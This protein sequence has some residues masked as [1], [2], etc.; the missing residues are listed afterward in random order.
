MTAEIRSLREEDLD[1][2]LRLSQFAFQYE[3]APEEV[4]QRKKRMNPSLTL[5][6][7]EDG[8]M[9]AKA[10]FLPLRAFIAGKPFAMGGVAGV[11]TWP[12]HRR[13]GKVEALLRRGLTFMRERGETV[14][15]LAPF[16]F[17][18][19]ARYG[20]TMLTERKQYTF[21]SGRV[22]QLHAFEIPEGG[23]IRRVD[24]KSEWQ[25]LN[26]VYRQHAARFNGMLDRD[27]DWWQHSVLG[28]RKGQAAVYF[29][30]D[31]TAQGYLLY[32]VAESEVKVQEAVWLDADAQGALLKFLANHDSMAKS[33]EM[34]V[35]ASDRLPYLLRNPNLKQELKPYFMFRVVDVEAFVPAYP[36]KAVAGDLSV[37]LTDEHAP[38]NA[39]AYTWQLDSSGRAALTRR[40]LGDGDESIR[41]D[42]AAFSAMMIGAARPVFLRETGRLSGSDEAVR[43][44]ESALPKCETY[45]QDFF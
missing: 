23:G 20:W 44:W 8:A 27:E 7:F 41:C 39:G 4:E 31:G 28:Q 10:S 30:P 15:M 25:L 26:E 22:A 21:E 38:W 42:I 16:S 40:Q 3:L 34:T 13:T 32:K 43:R 29:G 18:F 33:I 5:A 17:E 14:S 24:A 9:A 11:A 6:W 37:E 1:E 19:Y 2:S 35:P 12:E 36:F 45:L